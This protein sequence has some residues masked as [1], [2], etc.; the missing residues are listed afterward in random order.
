MSEHTSH[1]IAYKGTTKFAY[2]QEK[3]VIIFKMIDLSINP[4][5]T[6]RVRKEVL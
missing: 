1:N 3:R 4:E 2:L 5:P 6:I